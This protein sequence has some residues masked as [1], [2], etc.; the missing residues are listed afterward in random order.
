ML[1]ST[2]F[3]P[4]VRW[5][6]SSD[7]WPVI[8]ASMLTRGIWKSEVVVSTNL[9]ISP[10][11]W[12]QK[13]ALIKTIQKTIG[14]SNCM[15]EEKRKCLVHNQCTFFAISVLFLIICVCSKSKDANFIVICS[16]R[17]FA[18][19]SISFKC[20]FSFSNL[21]LSYLMRLLRVL[22]S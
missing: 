11:I 6:T 10:N 9:R 16:I 22:R 21:L 15:E 20:L 14:K 2:Q 5:P 19:I 12:S 3:R 13:G 1:A 18:S 4:A 8:E 17:F 7:G